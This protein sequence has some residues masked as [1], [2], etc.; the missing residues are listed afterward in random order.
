MKVYLIIFYQYLKNVKFRL[1]TAKDINEIE[2]LDEQL[3]TRNK[4]D[5]STKSILTLE[6][7][8]MSLDGEKDKIKISNTIKNLKI[9]DTRSLTKYIEEIT[10]GIDLNTVARTQGGESAPT[11][12][13]FNRSFFWPEL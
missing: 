6:R 5:I 1:L 7:H 10:P 12:L 13:K 11:F 9:M 2:L 8:I 4:T 3:M